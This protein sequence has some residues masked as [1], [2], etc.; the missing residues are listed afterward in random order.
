MTQQYYFPAA[1]TN[2]CQ[3]CLYYMKS[4]IIFFVFSYIVTYW[5][6]L[7]LKVV[8]FKEVLTFFYT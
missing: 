1:D 5:K 4:E 8:D 2:L 7:Q 3:S 6:L